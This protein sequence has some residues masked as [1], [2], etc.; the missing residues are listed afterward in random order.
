[1]QAFEPLNPDELV[2]HALLS[3]SDDIVEA[4]KERARTLLFSWV[5][6][7]KPGVDL[8]LAAI[9]LKCQLLTA[10]PEHNPLLPHLCEL[11]D[12]VRAHTGRMRG[13]RR[14]VRADA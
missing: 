3:M 1:M 2:V 4:A 14:H 5:L 9:D 8:G 10:S 11:L 12:E 13:R 7:L 6:S